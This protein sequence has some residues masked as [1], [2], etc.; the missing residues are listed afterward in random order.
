VLGAAAPV[1]LVGLTFHPWLL[2]AV[3]IDVAIAVVALT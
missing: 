1:A 2:A 3:A